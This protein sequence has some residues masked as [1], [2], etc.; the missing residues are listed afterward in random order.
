MKIGH[1]LEPDTEIGP[2]INKKRLDFIEQMVEDT[3]NEGATVACGGKRPA[4][5]NKGFFYEPTVFTDVTDDMRVMNDEPFG[6]IAPV[7]T[8]E[9]FD[10]VITRAN[11]LS[12]GLAGYVFTDSQALAMKTMEALRT[13]IVGVNNYVAATAEMPFGGVNHSGFGRENGPNGLL[14]Y[15]DVKF[16]NIMMG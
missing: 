1:G 10:E 13:G 2:L 8:F 16:A 9:D 7:T 6:P 14:D 12:F 15:M 4:D 3:R 5:K 11:S